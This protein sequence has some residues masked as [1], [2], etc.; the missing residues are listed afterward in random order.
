MKFKMCDEQYDFGLPW[1]QARGV[2]LR[3]LLSACLDPLREEREVSL[4]QGSPQK[5]FS[6]K[7][8]N[9][10]AAVLVPLLKV[11]N[12]WH[13]LMTKRS[14]NLSSHAGQISFPGGKVENSD[15]N[16]ANAALR[17]AFEEV[18]LDPDWVELLGELN[19]VKS[20][21]GFLVHPF[22]GVVKGKNRLAMLKLDPVEVD[23]FFTLPLAHILNPNNFQ[24]V[25]RET[26][27]K[28]ND[29]WAID[30][31]EHFIWGLSARVLIDLCQRFATLKKSEI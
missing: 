15:I 10:I 29:Y 21:A 20:P 4:S 9:K 27:G 1:A 13:I 17:E 2:D 25:P 30:Y 16:P 26:D 24:L 3:D 11:K 23:F 14:D 8:V 19:L 7:S 28:Q 5:A 31:K 22:V 12:E 6:A 18:R